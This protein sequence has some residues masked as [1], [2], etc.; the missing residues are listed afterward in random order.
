[1][2][3]KETTGIIYLITNTVNGKVY[4]G[5]TQK[6]LEKRWSEHCKSSRGKST[7]AIHRAIRKYGSGTFTLKVL[8]TSVVSDLNRLERFW[9]NSLTSISPNGYNLTAG[10]DGLLNPSAETLRKMSEKVKAAWKDPVKRAAINAA[11]KDSYDTPER[12]EKLSTAAKAMWNNPEFRE[13]APELYRQAWSPERRKQFGIRAEALWKNP[14]FRAKKIA[15]FK[16]QHQDPE[17]RAKQ[18]KATR[19]KWADPKFRRAIKDAQDRAW[20]DPEKRARTIQAIRAYHDTPEAKQREQKYWTDE[21]RATSSAAA[22]ER[23]NRPEVQDRIADFWTPEQRQK[24]GTDMKAIWDRPGHKE[25]VG[26]KIS[27]TKKADKD[28]ISATAKRMWENPE[29][30]E[31]LITYLRS[32]ERIEKLKEYTKRFWKDPIYRAEMSRKLSIAQRARRQ[33]EKLLRG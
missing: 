5:K 21:R 23:R 27:A 26:P 33:R 25:K 15:L 2:E 12:R 3:P 4:V 8:A 22:K 14:T 30:R 10:G 9:I 18:Q 17:F 7:S 11:R 32:P 16:Q 1:M 6:T 29:S 13:R 24:R 31:K 28:R 19:E 20:A